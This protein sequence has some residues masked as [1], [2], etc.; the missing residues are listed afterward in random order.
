VGGAVIREDGRML[1]IRRP[2]NGEWVLPGGI[3]ELDKD[4]RD[5]VRREVLEESGVTVEP[6][7]LT[8]V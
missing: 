1:A 6:D 2:D 8:G 4:P 7:Q 5:A 3:V